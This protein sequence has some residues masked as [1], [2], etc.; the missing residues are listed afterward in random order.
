VQE[1]VRDVLTAAGAPDRRKLRSN[2]RVVTIFITDAGEQSAATDTARIPYIPASAFNGAS[3]V[4]N[5]T[6][7]LNSSVT[8]WADFFGNRASGGWD[9][10]RADEPAMFLAGILCPLATQPTNRNGGTTNGCNGEE[11]NT[12]TEAAAFS[13]NTQVGAQRFGIQRYYNVINTLGGLTGSIAD[14]FG[15]GFAGANL[16]NISV[17]IEAILRA[18]VTASS[19]YQLTEDPIAS[20]IKVSLETPTVGTCNLADVP[21]VTD[22]NGNGFLYDAATNRI[23]FVGTCRPAQTGTDVVA[24]Y[25]TWI[26]LTADPNGADQP[27][28]GGCPDPLVC[29]NDQCVCPTD[30]AVDGGL[31]PSQTCDTVSDVNNDGFPDCIAECL[32]DC[33]GCPIGSV[34]D[35]DSPTCACSCPADC[36]FGGPLPQ[37]FVCNPATCQAECAPNGCVGTPPGPNYVCGANCVYECP[38]DCGGN[39]G[40]NERCNP[41]TCEPECSPDCNANCS[42]A[43]SC[44]ADTCACEC[45]TANASSCAPGFVFDPDACGCVC[46]VDALACGPT[47]IADPSRCVCEC[48]PNCGNA[49]SGDTPVC[50]GDCTC[51]GIGG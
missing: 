11:D 13:A 47:R 25:R 33:G 18:V 34:C 7:A 49:C 38:A 26:D 9:P 23:A 17:T 37:G 35:V 21:R 12:G 16:S 3:L 30:C 8:F 32:P 2:A 10:T 24:S 19:P 29:I 48:A 40:D 1:F 20:T 45:D 50:S 44:N 46:D 15:D 36:N 4:P 28:D 31:L 43:L 41:T 14:T 42:G 6:E 51:A 39:L 22:L 5:E 27:C